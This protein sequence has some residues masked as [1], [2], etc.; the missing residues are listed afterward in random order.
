MG[1]CTRNEVLTRMGRTD[2]LTDATTINVGDAI[3]AATAAIDEDCHRH[4]DTTG[5]VLAPVTKTLP[6]PRDI[7]QSRLDIPDLISLTS[8]SVDD[9]NDGVYET[10]LVAADYELDKWHADTYL[11]DNGARSVW[12]Y[13]FVTLLSRYWPTGTRRNVIQIDGVW[14]W[15]EVPAAINQACS[16]LATRLMQR[17]QAAPFGVQSFGG[18]ATQSIRTTDSD[19]LALIAPYRRM[20][21]V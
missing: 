8:I 2:T 20:G 13:E 1:Y 21:V 14:G 17:M 9:N 3:E 5:T 12:P 10:V 11:D 18:E 4:F 6:R 19:Y 7:A 16:I 15:P